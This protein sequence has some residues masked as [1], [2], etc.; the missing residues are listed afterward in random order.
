MTGTT[1]MMTTQ[2]LGICREQTRMNEVAFHV[3]WDSLLGWVA[4]GA[5]A[6]FVWILKQF[7]HQHIESIKSLAVELREMRKELNSLAERVKVVEV[8]QK[9]YHTERDDDA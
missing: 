3:P 2:D 9:H 5:F 8:V 4:T 6:V 7:G 1:M